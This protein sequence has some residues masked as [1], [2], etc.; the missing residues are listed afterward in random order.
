MIKGISIVICT[1]NGSQRLKSVLDH[2]I[3]LEIPSNLE[4]EVLV[5]DNA[6]TDD[7]FIK[8]NNEISNNQWPSNFKIV[9]ESKAGL[10][11]ARI[12]GFILS[13]FDW[14]LFCDDD[15]YIN[16]NCISSW[17]DIVSHF[18]D[19]GCVGGKGIP[20]SSVEFPSWFDKYSHSY[21]VGS[22]YYSDG[23]VEYG[24]SFF[25]ACLFIFKVPVLNFLNQGYRLVLSD[26][27]ADKLTSGGDLELCF[28]IQL[29]GFKLFYDSRI[30]FSH[31]IAPARLTLPYYI[32]LKSGIASG[33]GLIES[34]LFIFKYGY[35]KTIF[36]V[37][38]YYIKALQSLL[39]LIN[40]KIKNFFLKSKES[41][42]GNAL[43]YSILKS[44]CI[45]YFTNFHSSVI[46]YKNLLIYNASL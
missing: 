3:R 24:N 43:A 32:K 16:P 9:S 1:Y 2:L 23:F 17:F 38:Y 11:N 31:E 29:S 6:S 37:L 20:V 39:L 42:F 41:H 10:N 19:V 4:W 45:S 12:T 28:L 33:V 21:A 14:V 44:K 36:F 25:G 27:N 35:K 26:R 46:H 18:G 5:V 15:N 13:K 34:Y 40:F 30:I 7:T 8:Y 22:Q